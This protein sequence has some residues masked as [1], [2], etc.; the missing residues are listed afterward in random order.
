[1][2]VVLFVVVLVL[3][4]LT[5]FTVQTITVQN[6]V[7][8]PYIDSEGI[9]LAS[10]VRKGSNIF[11]LNESSTIAK[12]EAAHPYLKVTNIERKFPNGVVYHVTMRDAQFAIRVDGQTNYVILDSNLMAMDTVESSSALYRSSTLVSGVQI[13]DIDAGTILNPSTSAPLAA[14]RQ[15]CIVGEGE[16]LTFGHFFSDI[17]FAESV[18]Y[19]KVRTGATIRI[20][21][22]ASV[23]V[24]AYCRTALELFSTYAEG[25]RER[26]TGYYSWKFDEE[27]MINI[28]YWSATDI[29][30]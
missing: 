3:L 19:I 9:F 30:R 26:R 22:Y 10:G 2:L 6:E 16:Q 8:S 5:L 25:S 15:L 18:M 24:Q 13:G 1:M 7:E 17:V 14:I 21:H 28:C 20:D 23:D 27:R 11:L 29:A 4:N 12:I